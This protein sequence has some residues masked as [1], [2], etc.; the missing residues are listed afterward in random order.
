MTRVNSYGTR[1]QSYIFPFYLLPQLV[2]FSLRRNITVVVRMTMEFEFFFF[3]QHIYG[4]VDIMQNVHFTYDSKDLNS[5]PF[6][7]FPFISFFLVVLFVV[8]EWE[9]STIPFHFFGKKSGNS[10][11][12][13]GGIFSH[14]CYQILI[15]ITSKKNTN[16]H[17]DKYFQNWY[18][19]ML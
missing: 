17:C 16:T 2:P 10:S 8:Y 13:F 11:K 6:F 3:S 7:P 9:F 15:N 18:Y 12:R 1:L 19:K 4:V 14:E 5:F